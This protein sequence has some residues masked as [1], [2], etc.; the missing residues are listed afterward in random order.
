MGR[1]RYVLL[2]VLAAMAAMAFTGTAA[3]GEVAPDPQ[4]TNVPYLAWAGNQVNLTKCFTDE[5]AE[6]D[7]AQ[8]PVPSL[9]GKFVVEDW[10]GTELT[11]PTAGHA[12]KE[13][14]FL[15]DSD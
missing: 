10:S 1:L 8:V 12:S 7:I 3:A 2:A 6:G 11:G 13:P 15:N 9:Y 4:T 5:E 14:Q